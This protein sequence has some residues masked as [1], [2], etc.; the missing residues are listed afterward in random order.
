M[1]KMLPVFIFFLGIICYAQDSTTVDKMELRNGQVLIGKVQI[2]KTDVVDFKE[3]DTGLS[4]ETAKKEIRYI[5]L[6]N[7]KILT[8]E[9]DYKPEKQDD[10]SIVQQQPQVSKDDSGGGTPAGLII[11]ATVGVVLVILLIIGA[12]AQ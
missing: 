6:A 10:K 3:K 12:A 9:E 1:K 5:Q 4:Y 11:L 8:F 2:I 7:G